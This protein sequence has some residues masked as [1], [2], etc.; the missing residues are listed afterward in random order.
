MLQGSTLHKI[1]DVPRISR[2]FPPFDFSSFRT[3]Y[4][5]K[6]VI[7]PEFFGFVPGRPIDPLTRLG[8]K[9]NEKRDR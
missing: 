2:G 8:R 1:I 4:N 9:E 3:Q 7:V 5:N 6:L